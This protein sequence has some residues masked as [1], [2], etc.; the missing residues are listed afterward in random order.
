MPTDPIYILNCSIGPSF[1]PQEVSGAVI[2]DG[3]VLIPKLGG[4]VSCGL[5]GIS[6]DF[7]EEYQIPEI[8]KNKWLDKKTGLDEIKYL[9]SKPFRTKF[10]IQ[11]IASN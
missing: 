5:F 8:F 9:T 3:H 1:A 6:E 7:I 2:P 11:T 10:V 4:R